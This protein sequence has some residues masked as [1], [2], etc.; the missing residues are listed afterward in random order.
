M[1]SSATSLWSAC[2]EHCRVE[3]LLDNNFGTD[4]AQEEGGGA[5]SAS[6]AIAFAA[7]GCFQTRLVCH[8]GSFVS[9]HKYEA[10]LVLRISHFWDIIT[11]MSA[12]TGRSEI[13]NLFILL[14]AIRF[15]TPILVGT[16]CIETKGRHAYS[17]VFS[18]SHLFLLNTLY[19]GRRQQPDHYEW[20]MR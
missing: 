2:G 19:R 17:M 6:P 20:S 7:Q 11:L 5:S 18:S 10:R 15:Q 8:Q 1:S 12:L 3:M 4:T 14:V 13:I 9:C 16:R